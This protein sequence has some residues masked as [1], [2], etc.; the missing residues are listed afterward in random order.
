M[1]IFEENLFHISPRSVRG[2]SLNVS[3]LS[4][5][6]PE[7]LYGLCIIV[8]YHVLES[9]CTSFALAT[10]GQTTAQEADSLFLRFCKVNGKEEL[11]L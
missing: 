2:T 3:I 9:S 1:F 11:F 8:H 5:N 10:K 4:S 6:W 7:F